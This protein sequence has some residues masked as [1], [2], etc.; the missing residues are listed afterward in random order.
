MDQRHEVVDVEIRREIDVRIIYGDGTQIV[1]DVGRLRAV[2][3]C[4]H[5]RG[6]R[7]RGE[8][9]LPATSPSPLA[10]HPAIRIVDAKLAGAWG[11]SIDWSDGHGSGIYAWSVLRDWWDAGHDGPLVADP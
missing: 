2:C 10:V 11:L 6:R 3:P 1:V 9:V 5:C 4:A 7:E 8:P